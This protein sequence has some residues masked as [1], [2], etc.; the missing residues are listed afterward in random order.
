MYM[1]VVLWTTVLEQSGQ[2]YETFISFI[3][4]IRV[5]MA[6]IRSAKGKPGQRW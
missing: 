2:A 3:F 1:F 5:H 4:T 6:H